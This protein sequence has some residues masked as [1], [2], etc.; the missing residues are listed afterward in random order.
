MHMEA[1]KLFFDYTE[2][3]GFPA[4]PG[5]CNVILDLLAFG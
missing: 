3:G 2:F 4:E 5:V 1:S